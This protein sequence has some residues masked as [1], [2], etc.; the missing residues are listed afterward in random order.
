MLG[1]SWDEAYAGPESVFRFDDDPVRPTSPVAFASPKLTDAFVADRVGA[2]PSLA[3]DLVVIG[4][5]NDNDAAH[6]T[7][8]TVDATPTVATIND[9]G[10]QDFFKVNLVAGQTY[11]IGEYQKVAGP[12][13]IPL[14]DAYFE[15][16]GPMERWW[17]R[18]TAAVRTRPRGWTR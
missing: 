7:L 2:K 1:Y 16:F 5:L 9:I 11:S 18:W 13:G 12:S 14:P 15:L 17:P 3:P 6:A 8:L 4:D 10:D